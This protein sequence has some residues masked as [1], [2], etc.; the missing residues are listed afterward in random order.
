MRTPLLSL[1]CA[2]MLL[3]ASGCDPTGPV[4][5]KGDPSVKD[6]SQE[7]LSRIVEACIIG[8]HA[9]QVKLH[10]RSGKGDPEA[11]GA[12][13]LSD[14]QLGELVKAHEA[15]ATSDPA[16]VAKWARGD[17]SEFDA[18]ATLKP[19]EKSG[20]KLADNLPVE[21]ATRVLTEL[22]PDEKAIRIRAMASLLQ[23]VLEIN[24]DGEILQDMFRLYLPIGL[25]VAPTDLGIE[26]SNMRFLEVG[27]QLKDCCKAPISTKR[28]N[29]QISLRKIQNWSRMHR[30]IGP[31]E[32]AMEMLARDD[33]RPHITKIRA[34]SAQR[35]LVIGHSF[36]M[37][38]NWSSIAKMNEIAAAVF[39]KENP[40][41]VFSHMGHGGMNVQQARDKFLKPAL[42]W[43]PDRVLI[44]AAAW[45]DAQLEALEEMATTFKRIGAETMIFDQLY[46]GSDQDLLKYQTDRIAEIS[47]RTGLT[48]IEVG[49]LIQSHP[50]KRK[51]VCLDG[52]HMREPY[53]ELLGG[54][55]LKYLIGAREAKLAGK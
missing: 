32:L 16:E 10:K 52:I 55:L 37:K 31:A 35:I 24:R 48:V 40:G 17:E 5:K 23:L 27:T 54:E 22:A 51:F 46:V 49:K 43:K 13:G 29:W 1:F 36:T 20:L 25:L 7:K 8:T 38:V 9:F 26:D 47:K 4:D 50:K 15:L 34:L 19:L 39:Q 45:N 11:F 3:T 21:A 12:Q 6:F 14:E 42:A 18:E 41:V 33:I 2:C 44:V 28:N 53:H 30:G